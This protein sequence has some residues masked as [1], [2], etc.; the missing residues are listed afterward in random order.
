M[1]TEFQSVARLVPAGELDPTFDLEIRWTYNDFEKKKFYGDFNKLT[2]AGKIE[3]VFITGIEGMDVQFH[4]LD[5]GK[6]ENYFG[7]LYGADDPSQSERVFR[8]HLSVIENT[9]KSLCE[10]KIE[11]HQEENAGL[12][13]AL[14]QDAPQSFQYWTAPRGDSGDGMKVRFRSREDAVKI[15]RKY[16]KSTSTLLAGVYPRYFYLFY[17]FEDEQWTGGIIWN[18]ITPTAKRALKRSIPTSVPNGAPISPPVPASAVLAS[19]Q[20]DEYETVVVKR[21]KVTRA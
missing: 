4:G 3:R 13:N 10:S 18:M 2:D 21:K 19:Q 8:S 5:G 9:V 6:D 1:S 11:E 15:R 17:N 7:R 14:L 20:E 16:L 12:V